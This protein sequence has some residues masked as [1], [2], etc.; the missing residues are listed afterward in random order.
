[1][2]RLI[3]P[4]LLVAFGLNSC[5]TLSKLTQFEKSVQDTVTI[6]VAATILT[7][8]ISV[9]SPEIK[10]DMSKFLSDNKIDTAL[11]QKIS[12]KKLEMTITVPAADTCTFKFLSAVEVS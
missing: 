4:L 8:P 1:M 5:N 6:P 11:I 3:F 7:L 2:K 10:T 9:G 12:L